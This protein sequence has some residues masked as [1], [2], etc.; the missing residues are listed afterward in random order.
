MTKASQQVKGTHQLLSIEQGN[1][2]DSK[3]K[4]MNEGGSPTVGLRDDLVQ[5]LGCATQ[6]WQG[7]W[8]DAHVDVCNTVAV[9]L[10]TWQMCWCA[11]HSS[12]VADL[13]CVLVHATWWWCGGVADSASVLVCTTQQQWCC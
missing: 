13:A 1:N 4:P 8:L 3:Q 5:V 12:G 2:Q 10:L 6:W 7:H 11:Q 9:G